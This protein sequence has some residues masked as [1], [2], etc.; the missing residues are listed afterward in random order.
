MPPYFWA[1]KKPRITKSLFSAFYLP[2]YLEEGV[3]I[4]PTIYLPGL[5]FL[6]ILIYA[7][8]FHNT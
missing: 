6:S 8:L 1:I 4:A 3:N 5:D 2:Y 7:I